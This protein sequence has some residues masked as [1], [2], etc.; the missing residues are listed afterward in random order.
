MTGNSSRRGLVFPDYRYGEH[1]T[2]PRIPAN[3]PEY[4]A[5]QPIS[6]ADRRTMLRRHFEAGGMTPAQVEAA[7]RGKG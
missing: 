2:A 6:Q 4:E 3:D 1:G 5:S 7:M